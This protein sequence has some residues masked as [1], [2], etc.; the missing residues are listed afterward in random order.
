M[1]TCRA[2]EAGHRIG[3]VRATGSRVKE[4]CC[5]RAAC[6]HL[7]CCATEHRWPMCQMMCEFARGWCVSLQG[8]ARS[9]RGGLVDRTISTSRR[10][11]NEMDIYKIARVTVCGMCVSAR[12]ATPVDVRGLHAR[13]SLGTM[14][15]R[16]AT[17]PRE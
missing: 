8:D 4:G 15:L 3:H 11:M 13:R 14:P 17:G 10:A 9:R 5:V 12:Q 2:M 16:C 7:A 6:G 1:T